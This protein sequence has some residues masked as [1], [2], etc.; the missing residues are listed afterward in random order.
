M[1]SLHHLASIDMK[2]GMMTN[3]TSGGSI[4]P[5]Q[6]Q[7]VLLRDAGQRESIMPGKTKPFIICRFSDQN[8]AQ[9]V[10]LAHDPQSLA[11][12]SRPNTTIL[13]GRI[14]PHRSQ[15][16]PTRLSFHPKPNRGKSYLTGNHAILFRYKRKRQRVGPTQRVNDDWLHWLGTRGMLRMPFK[17][18]VQN[19]VN[20]VTVRPALRSNLHVPPCVITPY[21]SPEGYGLQDV[22]PSKM[23]RI[24]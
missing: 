7:N 5:G 12:Q 2:C 9:C 19:M 14:H 13:Q 20:D 3:Y 8:N 15:G 6:P 18:P 10:P 11:N 22:I 1:I 21:D 24:V 16:E 4:A 23:N 17:G